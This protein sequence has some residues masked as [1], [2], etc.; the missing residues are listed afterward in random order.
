MKTAT[1]PQPQ[2]IPRELR[3]IANMIKTERKRQKISLAKLSEMVYGNPYRAK[4]LSEIERSLCPQIPFMT[5][6]NVLK[7]LGV[8][9]I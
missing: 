2:K 6:V 9:V 3:A 8:E 1:K 4:A 5:I 7:A